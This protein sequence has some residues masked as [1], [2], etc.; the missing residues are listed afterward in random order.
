ME[1]APLPPP[2]PPVIDTLAKQPDAGADHVEPASVPSVKLSALPTGIAGGALVAVALGVGALVPEAVADGAALTVADDEADTPRVSVAVGQLDRVAAAV[3]DDVRLG[4][5]LGGH[6]KYSVC[7]D[8]C[9]SLI[10]ATVLLFPFMARSVLLSE[11]VS[12]VLAMPADVQAAGGVQQ[13]ETCVQRAQVG[14]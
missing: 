9:V 12:Q 8:A 11:R 5:A 10:E 3:L 7:D 1:P 2:P 14:G 13:P 4:V 6:C